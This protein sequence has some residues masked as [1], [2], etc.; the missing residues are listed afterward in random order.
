M[1]TL[2]PDRRALRTLFRS[3]EIDGEFNWDGG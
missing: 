3:I 2:C 1:S